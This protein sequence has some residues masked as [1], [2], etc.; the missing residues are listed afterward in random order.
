MSIPS[1][2]FAITIAIA[3]PS[4]SPS[5]NPF[6]VID[7]NEDEDEVTNAGKC[8]GDIK[9]ESES[10]ARSITVISNRNRTPNQTQNELD[11][12]SES[13]IENVI[14]SFTHLVLN[15]LW[16]INVKLDRLFLLKDFQM[17]RKGVICTARIP[18]DWEYRWHWAF[19]DQRFNSV[20]GVLKVKLG[21]GRRNSKKL[22]Y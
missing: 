11:S 13:S 20:S 18:L 4:P 14:V 1:I 17:E 8:N 7:V 22:K 2:M 21:T 5:I 10:D 16:A 3:L 12:E 19:Y 6:T 9:P 15:P